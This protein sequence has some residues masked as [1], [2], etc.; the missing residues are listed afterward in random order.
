MNQMNN[1]FHCNNRNHQLSSIKNWVA[2]F[3]AS[4]YGWFKLISHSCPDFHTKYI[5]IIWRAY[6]QVGFFEI[7]ESWIKVNNHHGRMIQKVQAVTKTANPNISIYVKYFKSSLCIYIYTYIYIWHYI[8]IYTSYPP[9]PQ[10]QRFI[11]PCLP[12]IAL[13]TGTNSTRETDLWPKTSFG[14][15]CWAPTKMSPFDTGHHAEA[16][17]R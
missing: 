12:G 13:T 17:K 16:P 3:L 11:L 8:Y 10:P 4:Y 14:W 9:R 15:R 2:F 6:P 5:H 7:I 1:L